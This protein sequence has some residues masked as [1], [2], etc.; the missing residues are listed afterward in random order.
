MAS[1]DT[2]TS[3]A[4]SNLNNR[5]DANRNALFEI[6]K[7]M[8][9]NPSVNE[10]KHLSVSYQ[11]ENFLI[12]FNGAFI[13]IWDLS[14]YSIKNVD[15]N[16]TLFKDATNY[17]NFSFGPTIVLHSPDENGN[18]IFSSRFDIPYVSTMHDGKGYIAA[19]LDSFFALKNS[20]H[21]EINRLK[22]DPQD[23]TLHDNPIGFDTAS[24]SDPSSPQAN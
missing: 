8:G 3:E 24:L 19:L 18:I 7:E 9:C 1:N 23:R 13:R 12:M 14:W 6:F 10:D 21:K 16:F 15:D 5:E 11:G 2:T 17:A 22:E 4:E 20:L